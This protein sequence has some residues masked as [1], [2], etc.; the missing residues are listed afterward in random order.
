[1]KALSI[2]ILALV[3]L[4]AC[5]PA[6]TPVPVKEPAPQPEPVA[7]APA[8]ADSPAKVVAS[9]VAG[10]TEVV[11]SDV[12]D[13]TEV[14][15]VGSDVSDLEASLEDLSFEEFDSL[16]ADLGDLEDLDY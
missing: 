11:A 4:S 3:I 8:S 12:A 9:D 1:M 16:A 10:T 5:G 14:V 7:P 6:T 2:V 13:T 15:S